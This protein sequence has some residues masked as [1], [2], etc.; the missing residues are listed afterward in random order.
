MLFNGIGVGR[1][2]LDRVVFEFVLES[3]V[4][5]YNFFRA[6]VFFLIFR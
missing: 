5:V 4:L 1:L 3:V 6:F 2:I